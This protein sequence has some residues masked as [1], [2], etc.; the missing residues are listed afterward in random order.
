MVRELKPTRFFHTDCAD[1]RPSASYVHSCPWIVCGNV[2]LLDWSV[3]FSGKE[4]IE[5][6]DLGSIEKIIIYTYFYVVLVPRTVFVGLL[7]VSGAQLDHRRSARCVYGTRTRHTAADGTAQHWTC[8]A[9]DFNALCLRTRYI[10]VPL[11]SY[12]TC[13]CHDEHKSKCYGPA[14]I[15]RCIYLRIR[16][17]FIEFHRF[18][19]EIICAKLKRSSILLINL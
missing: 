3:W 10:H 1:N 7:A 8:S 19:S 2:R 13:G 5:E 11:L 16:S 12:Q 9:R 17:P 15:N 18:H 4:T 14:C 6:I